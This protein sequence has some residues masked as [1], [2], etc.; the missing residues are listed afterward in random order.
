MRKVRMAFLEKGSGDHHLDK[1]QEGEDQR[2][3]DKF[4]HWCQ[5]RDGWQLT[6]EAIHID[7]DDQGGSECDP[8][9]SPQLQGIDPEYRP[10]HTHEYGNNDQNL[11]NVVSRM[12]CGPKNKSNR[13]NS[14][15]AG[16]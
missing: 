14:C 9:L 12:A 1:G 10:R 3:N 13:G 7:D 16:S 4:I 6:R 2:T 8:D 15:L 11:P 5:V